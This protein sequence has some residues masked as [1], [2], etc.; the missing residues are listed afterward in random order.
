MLADAF[1][2]AREE[3][4]IRAAQIWCPFCEGGDLY[5]VEY[6]CSFR[7]SPRDSSSPEIE[8]DG[9]VGNW[10]KR[11]EQLHLTPGQISMNEHRIFMA[12]HQATEAEL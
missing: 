10:C 6:I 4:R 3:A 2:K 9:L 8:V 5:T 12:R 1:N 7:R 11:C